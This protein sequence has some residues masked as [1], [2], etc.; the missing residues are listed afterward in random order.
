[1]DMK[2]YQKIN[3]RISPWIQAGYLWICYGYPFISK[4]DIVS[5]PSPY[6]VIFTKI[7]LRYPEFGYLRISRDMSG[8]VRISF[9]GELPDAA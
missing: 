8:Y 6:P 4:E 1:M 3:C 2:G 9:G 7:S 5:Y